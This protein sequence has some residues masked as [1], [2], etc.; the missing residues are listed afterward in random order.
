MRYKTPEE[1]TETQILSVLSSTQ[2]SG[3]ERIQAVLSAIFYGK[4]VEFSGDILIQEFT[5]AQYYEKRWL[6]NLFSTFYGMC[7]V[8]Y[9][10]EESITLLQ[11]YVEQEESCA[12]ETQAIIEELCEYKDMLR[13]RPA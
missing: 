1:K 9:R 3:E 7:R 10:I 8:N 2:S 13:H 12:D 6:K 4:T 11:S 5:E